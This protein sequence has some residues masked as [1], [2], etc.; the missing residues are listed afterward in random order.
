MPKQYQ[1]LFVAECGNK[2]WKEE[3]RREK[4]RER[5]KKNTQSDTFNS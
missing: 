4:R 3:K 1:T 2:F 5:E